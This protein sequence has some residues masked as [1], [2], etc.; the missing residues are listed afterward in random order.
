MD[1]S[2]GHCRETGRGD[3]WPTPGPSL[4]W[5]ASHGGGLWCLH[6]ELPFVTQTDLPELP[7]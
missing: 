7:A 6:G 1:G 5:L 4:G 3:R 2:G